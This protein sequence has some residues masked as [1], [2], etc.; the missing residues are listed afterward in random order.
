M[1]SSIL[2][3]DEQELEA[4]LKCPQCDFE[5][6]TTFE[7]LFLGDKLYLEFI[8]DDCGYQQNNKLK[9]ESRTEVIHAGILVSRM[10]SAVNKEVNEDG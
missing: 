1:S 3:N 4:I 6:V 10:V 7:Y 9:L 2:N 5:G 8:C